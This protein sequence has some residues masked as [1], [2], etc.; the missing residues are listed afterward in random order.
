[1][2]LKISLTTFPSVLCV[3]IQVLAHRANYPR[4]TMQKI[5][6]LHSCMAHFL[7]SQIVTFFGFFVPVSVP[8]HS[9]TLILLNK[10]YGS[11][12]TRLMIGTHSNTKHH[13][14]WVCDFSYSNYSENTFHIC[15]SNNLLLTILLLSG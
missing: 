8:Q 2:V 6:H 9:K 11:P 7:L 12:F 13:F 15:E 1:M 5:L 3:I 14:E 10:S 4:L